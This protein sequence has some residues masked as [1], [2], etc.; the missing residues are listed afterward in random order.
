MRAFVTMHEGIPPEAADHLLDRLAESH[1]DVYWTVLV[2]VNDIHFLADD[3]LPRLEGG[4]DPA[5]AVQLLE[6][7]GY[8]VGHPEGGHDGDQ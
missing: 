1:P 6:E 2:G 5:R 3:D 8:I 4:F 7:L